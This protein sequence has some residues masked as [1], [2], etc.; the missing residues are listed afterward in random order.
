PERAALHVKAHRSRPAQ[1]QPTHVVAPAPTAA[2]PPRPVAK[3][4][5]TVEPQPK[6]AAGAPGE[7]GP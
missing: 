5:A 7:F 1:A 4:Q 2:A 6:P 3:Q